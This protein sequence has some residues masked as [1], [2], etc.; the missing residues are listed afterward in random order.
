MNLRPL[1]PHSSALP[2]CATS[3]REKRDTRN[4]GGCQSIFWIGSFFSLRDPGRAT[5]S[6]CAA[7]GNHAAVGNA[8]KLA[9]SGTRARQPAPPGCANKTAGLCGPTT[10]KAPG[11]VRLSHRRG[12]G[13]PPRHPVCRAGQALPGHSA[14]RERRQRFGITMQIVIFISFHGTSIIFCPYEYVT[15]RNNSYCV[16]TRAGMHGSEEKNMASYVQL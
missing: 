3:R 5:G 10:H 12:G 4:R 7:S 11:A 6:P 13:L 14:R 9:S 1:E 2:D 8:G 16:F 15:S